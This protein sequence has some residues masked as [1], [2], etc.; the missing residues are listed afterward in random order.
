MINLPYIFALLL[1]YLFGSVPFALVI[2]KVFYKTDIRTQGSGNL[3]GTNAGRV[4]GKWAGISV[5]VLD[6]LKATIVI[7]VVYQFAPDAA[8]LAGVFATLGHSFPIFA[9]FKGGKSVSTAFGYLLGVSIL[10]VNKPI[11]LFLIPILLFFG[12]LKLTKWVS[13]SSMFSL[14]LTV[15]LSFFVQ[16]DRLISLYLVFIDIIVI[17]RHRSNIQ[18]LLKNEERK[19]T[20]L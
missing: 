11:E 13:F 19:V 1:G 8:A 10:I 12:T 20:W 3:G 4:L 18:R 14:T 16:G 9:Q 15:I 5:S 7:A 6:V 17:W 2:G